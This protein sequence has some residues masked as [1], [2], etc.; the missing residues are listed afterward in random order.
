MLVLLFVLRLRGGLVHSPE[1][2]FA[3]VTSGTFTV[4][5]VPVGADEVLLVEHRVVGTQEPEVAN[6]QANKAVIISTRV[7]EKNIII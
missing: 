4:Y 7:T 2:V 6:L 1:V 5:V 3:I